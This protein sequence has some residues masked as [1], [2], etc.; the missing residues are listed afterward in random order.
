MADISMCAGIGCP[1]R[2]R[3]HRFT[4]PKSFYQSYLN[5]TPDENGECEGYWEAESIKKQVDDT[6]TIIDNEKI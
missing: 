5:R 3:C 2:D 6:E 1:M 4:A